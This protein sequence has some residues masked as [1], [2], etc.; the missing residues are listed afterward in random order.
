MANTYTTNL[1][2][3]K[4]EVGGDTDQWGTHL[5][6]DLD[7]LDALFKADGTGTSVGLNVGTGK[8]L[9][10]GG[11]ATSSGTFTVSGTF[12]V[13]SAAAFTVASDL[14]LSGTGQIKVPVGTT[15]QRSGSPTSGMFRF[16]S[17]VAKFEGYNGTVW[18]AVGG[19]AVGG[20]NDELFVLNGKTVN[21]S[22]TIPSDKNA[23]SA[24]P[25][26]VDGVFS[27]TG[28]ISGTTLTIT[29]APTGALY[30]GSVIAGT[31]VTAG[32]TITAFGTG[33]GGVGTYTVS[34]SQTVSSTAITSA[35]VVTI[36][37]GSVWTVV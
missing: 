31:G 28:S 36:P 24:G 13:T 11:T 21:V 14:S 16:N 4:P 25:I 18:G 33:T 3:I 1:N 26:T 12:N 9:S 32:T 23:M 34:A 17:T 22:Y 19:G 20:G 7:S 30:I 6:Q 8:T 5:N 27:G 15:A 37:S 2:L 29:D 35:A 10:V